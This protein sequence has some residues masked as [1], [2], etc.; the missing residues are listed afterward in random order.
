L[1][2]IQSALRIF[3]SAKVTVEGHT[4]SVGDPDLNHRLSLQ[5]AEAVRSYIVANMP[6][7]ADR[8]SAVGYGESVPLASNETADGRAKNRRIDIRL[9]YLYRGQ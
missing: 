1:T 5:R 2:K 8:I 3:P 6:A 7:D 4:D 9:S